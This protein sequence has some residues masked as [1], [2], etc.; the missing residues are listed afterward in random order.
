MRKVFISGGAGFIGSHLT[1]RLLAS[2]EMAKVIIYDN[3][4]S[5]TRGHLQEIVGDPRLQ[6]VEGDL[7][8]LGKLTTAMTGCG[9]V[10]HLAANPDIAKAVTHPD[11]DFWEGTYLAQNVL[12]AVRVN[13]VG[14]CF[15]PLEAASTASTLTWRFPKVLV[16]AC[17][18]QPTVP[19]NWPARR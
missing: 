18:S 3:F 11:I 4:S 14:A 15:T 12:E 6:I 9:T 16:P 19:A 5:G 10:F 1:R 8:D 2:P 7:K 13:G 17:Q